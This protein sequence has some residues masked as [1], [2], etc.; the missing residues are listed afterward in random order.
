MNCEGC[1]GEIDLTDVAG[2]YSGRCSL[3]TEQE[4]D[5]APDLW[6]GGDDYYDRNNEGSS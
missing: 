3:C 4:K 5:M 1:D 6:A 2:H